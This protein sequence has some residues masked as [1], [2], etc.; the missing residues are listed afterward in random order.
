MPSKAWV[1]RLGRSWQVSRRIMWA[2]GDRAWGILKFQCKEWWGEVGD[3]VILLWPCSHNITKLQN[4]QGFLESPFLVS[5]KW[6]MWNQRRKSSIQNPWGSGGWAEHPG[7]EEKILQE[8]STCRVSLQRPS[9]T[10]NLSLGNFRPPKDLSSLSSRIYF[11]N[12]S[13]RC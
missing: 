9:S 11:L 7:L 10:K 1:V 8:V 3:E 5:G 13:T 12:S 2:R 6:K 4:Q